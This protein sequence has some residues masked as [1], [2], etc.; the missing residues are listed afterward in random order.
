[1]RRW[2]A[3][4]FVAGLLRSVCGILCGHLGAVSHIFPNGFGAAN[5]LV[6]RSLRA[7]CRFTVGSLR[8]VGGLV[9]GLCRAG[10]DGM[11]GIL[12][13][14]FCIGPGRLDVLLRPIL[15]EGYAT[16]RNNSKLSREARKITPGLRN[17]MVTT[18]LRAESIP[19]E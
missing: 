1:M 9:V 11:P 18:P 7:A 6:R 8:A 16:R 4:N 13:G 12:R 10:G 19:V 5:S 17:C 3:R 2:L 15:R 14:I